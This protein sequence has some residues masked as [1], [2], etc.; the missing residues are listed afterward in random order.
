[1]SEWRF[2]AFSLGLFHTIYYSFAL[3]LSHNCSVSSCNFL[4]SSPSSQ[5]INLSLFSM[6]NTFKGAHYFLLFQRN[7]PVKWKW[8]YLQKERKQGGK[9][10]KTTLRK[11]IMKAPCW[12]L[13]QTSRSSS[14]GNARHNKGR[15]ITSTHELWKKKKIL[16]FLH[17]CRT[18][19][20]T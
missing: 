6:R 1:M 4:N 16:P 11:K 2:S 15:V 7:N 10:W 8:R 13:T 5:F 3:S 9:A 18:N 12:A 14:P 17:P 19:R 20:T